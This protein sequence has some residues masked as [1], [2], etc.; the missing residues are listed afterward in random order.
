MAEYFRAFKSQNTSHRDYRP[1]F[2]PVFCY[3]EGAWMS[4]PDMDRPENW[5]PT[6]KIFFGAE[7][8]SELHDRARAEFVTGTRDRQ[9]RSAYLPSIITHIAPSGEPVYAQWNF[10]PMC[11]PIADDLPTTYLRQASADPSF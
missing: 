9:G 8:W 2:R 6:D 10:R 3:L 7:T 5:F 4:D 11:Q 1:Y